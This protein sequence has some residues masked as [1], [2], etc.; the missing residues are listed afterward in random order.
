VKLVGSITG[1]N[2]NTN[3]HSCSK[4]DQLAGTIV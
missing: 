3:S 4:I 1:G 2:D